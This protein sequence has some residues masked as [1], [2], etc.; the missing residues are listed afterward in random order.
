MRFK[1]L[2]ILIHKFFNAIDCAC[3]HCPADKYGCN[4]KTCEIADRN[5]EKYKKEKYESI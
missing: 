3:N 1:K 2:K 5:F 4:T